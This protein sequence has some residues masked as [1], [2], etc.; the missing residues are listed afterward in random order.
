MTHYVYA[1]KDDPLHRQRWR[2]PYDAATLDEFADL[3]GTGVGT[4]GFGIS[5]GLSIAADDPDDRRALAA[6]VDAVVAAGVGLVAL[7]LDDIPVRPGLGPEHARLSAWL[8]EHLAGRAELLLCP[9]EYTGTRATP[10]LDALAEGVPDG[11]PICWTGRTV[12]CDEILVSEARARADALGGRA[13]LLWDNYP[14]NDTIMADRLFL[15]PLRGREPGLADA[16]S[17]W[18]ANPLVQ[19]HASRLPLASVAAAMRGDDP[20]A[21][22]AREADALGWRVLAEGCDGGHPRALVADVVRAIGSADWVPP[23]LRLADWFERARRVDVPELAEEAGAWMTQLRAEVEVGRVAL[24]VIQDLHPVVR[25]DPDGR[26]RVAPPDVA[27]AGR[28]ALGLTALWPPLRRNPIS[29]LGPRCSFRPVIGQDDAGEWVIAGGALE[30]D[31][32]AVDHLVRAAFAALEAV[33]SPG[34][35]ATG[36]A[37]RLAVDVNGEAVIPDETGAFRVPPDAA[38]RVRVGRQV[39]QVRGPAAP[40]LPDRRLDP[41]DPP[42]GVP[43]R[44]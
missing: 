13:P 35:P 18:L 38:V 33:G 14:V 31:A 1:P 39:T 8:A 23:T 44:G 11:V 34:G 3:S 24:R 4:V 6:K 22:W 37:G 41:T 10:Y 2:E 32:N 36:R 9:T 21:A 15:G 19:P 20:A 43:G 30:E 16:C 17:G 5:P 42:S 27:D 28:Q 25:V 7:L 26:A 29:V 40:P 12:V